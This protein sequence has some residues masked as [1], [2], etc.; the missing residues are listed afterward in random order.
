MSYC[1]YSGC[2]RGAALVSMTGTA[3]YAIGSDLSSGADGA[4]E[5]ETVQIA[6]ATPGGRGVLLGGG[7]AMPVTCVPW[8]CEEDCQSTRSEN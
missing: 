5:T 3:F 2:W 6:I 1:A 4:A 8:T 7:F